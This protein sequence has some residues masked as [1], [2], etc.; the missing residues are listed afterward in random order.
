[1]ARIH[2]VCGTKAEYLKTAPVL[3]E[4][5]ARGVA[6]RLVDTGQHAALTVALRRA[7]GVR[8]PDH[9]LRRGADVDTVGQGVRWA[10]G[11]ALLLARPRHLRDVVFAGDDGLCV[12]HGDTVS[13]L[14]AAALGRRAGLRVAHLEAGL[15]SHRL[16]HPF[17][18]ELMRLLV[19]RIA[20]LLFAPDDVAVANLH[21][22]GVLARVVPT[23]GN[24]VVEALRRDAAVARPRDRPLAVFSTHRLEN[25]LHRRRLEAVVVLAERLAGEMDVRFLLHGPTRAA[26]ARRSLLDRLERSGVA[27]SPLLPHPEFVQLLREAHLVVT[28]GGSVQEECALLGVPTLLWRSRSE[29]P[30]GIGRNVVLSRYEGAVVDAFLARPESYRHAPAD[31]TATPSRRIVDVLLQE[32]SHPRRP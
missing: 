20:S 27:A 23:A 6:Y 17:P 22:M 10:A 25:L 1:M 14:L 8:E 3:R 4:L 2:V 32:L 31:M 24:T 12:V 18:E 16:L 30:D 21:R 26:L 15:R 5:D 9:V 19:M 7:L 29:R 11:V 13:T 28:D